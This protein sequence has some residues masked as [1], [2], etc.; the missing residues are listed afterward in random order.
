MNRFSQSADAMNAEKNRS[1]DC[2]FSHCWPCCPSAIIGPTGATGPIGPRGAT[3][4]TG[5][6]G[7]TGATGAAG[8]TGATGP[9]GAAGATGA[10]GPAGAA[11]AAGATGATGAA[12]A[13]G[14]TGAAGAT[15]AT[16][17]AGATGPTGPRGATGATGPTGT[18][19][20]PC[21]SRGEIIVNGG[22]EVFSGNIPANWTVNDTAL[23]SRVDLQGRVHSGDLAVHLEDGAVL[24]QDVAVGAGCFYEL[25]F[26]ARGEGSQ[27]G[28]IATVTYFDAQDRP[29]EGLVI[30]V[31]QQDMVNSN[32]V[33]AYYRGIATAAPAGTVRARIAFAVNA[34]GMQG[35]DLDDVSFSVK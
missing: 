30:R 10:T 9:T 8:A 34:S 28:V 21:R 33:F 1:T 6:A 12:G 15:G 20:C 25:S 13:T 16:G 31:R 7:A 32:R 17:A 24:Y 23:V 18:C 29:T 5:A 26:F 14:A 2:P 3:G 22:M 4:A 19:E 35:M 27:V 11:G